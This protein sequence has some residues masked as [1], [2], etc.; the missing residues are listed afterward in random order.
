M[1]G[2]RVHRRNRNRQPGYTGVRAG[3]PGLLVF[4]AL[5]LFQGHAFAGSKAKIEK[6]AA[7]MERGDYA[8]AYC[9]WKDLADDGVEEAQY[10]L[11]WM[12]HNGY[13]VAVDD[14]QAHEWWVEAADE[15]H[16]EAQFAL[17]MLLSQGRYRGR[18]PEE[19]VE[20]YT[21]AAENGHEEAS[22]VLLAM[23]SRGNAAAGSKVER[24]VKKGRIGTQV[25]ISVDLANI[26]EQPTTKSQRLVTLKKGTE[27]LEFG[28][29]GKWHQVWVPQLSRVAWIHEGLFE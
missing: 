13:G 12:Y 7:L 11:G 3:F 8:P 21:K 6:A 2:T 10:I 5:L 27:L 1:R 4:M 15:G 29:S 19:A 23:A 22:L 17:G 28:R 24:L 18:N 16:V 9:I 25:K 20:W 14:E 26:R